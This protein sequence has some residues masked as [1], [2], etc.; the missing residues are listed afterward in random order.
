MELN[1]EKKYAYAELE[2]ILNWLG[3]EYINKLPRRILQ[4]I[5]YEKKQS[6][7][8]QI[9]FSKPL[10]NQ[11]RQ[12]TKNMIA[13]LNC[14]YWLQDEEEKNKIKS[15]IRKNYE[16]KKEMERAKRRE[17]IRQRAEEFGKKNY[18]TSS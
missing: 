6:Y 14:K 13:Y 8:P 4:V 10:E 18:F 17:E 1:Y 9:D 15:S 5:K 2:E 16:K 3:S 7:K 12:E 11:V